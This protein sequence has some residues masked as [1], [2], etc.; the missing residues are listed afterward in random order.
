MNQKRR[1]RMAF[2]AMD[3]IEQKSSKTLTLRKH[4]IQTTSR[5]HSDPPKQ[6][7]SGVLG[8]S[9]HLLSLKSLA[10]PRFSPILMVLP[11]V[12]LGFIGFSHTFH[13]DLSGSPKPRY[14]RDINFT[15]HRLQV[16]VGCFGRFFAGVPWA[17]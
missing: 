12:S 16:R 15:E 7:I 1:L 5:F 4:Q 9:G 17:G 8:S 13:R 10:L 11:R 14:R 3:D 6:S 2:K